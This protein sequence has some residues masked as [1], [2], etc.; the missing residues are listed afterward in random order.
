MFENI[1][2]QDEVLR[3]LRRGVT[4]N[5]LPRSM[6]FYG[7]GYSGKCTTAL[8]LARVL[9]CEKSG[10]WNCPCRS[11]ELH[12]RMM[13]PNTLLLGTRYF[14]EEIAACAEVFR[15]CDKVS[16]RY[17]FIRS[18]R[19]LTR[20]F[21]P[22]L[23]EGN[24]AKL[25]KVQSLLSEVEEQMEFLLPGSQLPGGREVEKNIDV[26]K[27]L[28]TR[29]LREVKLDG[30]TIDRIRRANVWAQTTGSSRKIIILENADQMQE[31]ATNALLKTLEEPLSEVYFILITSRKNRIIPTIQSRLRPYRF[32]PRDA[33]T[34]GVVLERIF[35]EDPGEYSGIREYFLA[36]GV[37]LDVLR[38]QAAQFLES[39]VEEPDS[40]G[41]MRK[42]FETLK[43]EGN[44]R[45]FLEELSREIREHEGRGLDPA[46]LSCR[47]AWMRE[48]RETLYRFET[49]N[50]NAA[51]AAE[52]LFYSMREVLRCAVS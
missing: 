37:K 15:R 1:I 18:V 22:A 30:I 42:L 49:L 31:G 29:I 27:E 5:L 38:S 32:I 33:E 9:T 36:Y 51:L 3:D 34:S 44:F 23:W 25:K 16:T 13:H 17:L 8:E 47:Q 4:E 10:E 45:L 11:C 24:D 21:D 2:G 41:E 40:P 28:C 6:L 52:H 39:V 43:K 14:E 26:L 19:K 50:Q 48:I 46:L 20:R 35:R 7:P 12:R